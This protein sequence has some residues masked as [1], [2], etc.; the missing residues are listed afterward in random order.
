MKL[1]SEWRQ[2]WRGG[3]F[4]WGESHAAAIVAAAAARDADARVAAAQ[5]SDA[6]MLGG[7]LNKLTVQTARGDALSAALAANESKLAATTE[8]AK[9]TIAHAVAKNSSC[10]LSADAVSLL[11][12]QPA[13]R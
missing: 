10:D 6:A 1:I 7:Y 5:K 11:N 4:V 3:G 9:E 8:A 13:R 12:A 2:A